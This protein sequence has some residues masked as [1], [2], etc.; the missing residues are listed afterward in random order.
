MR[1]RKALTPELSKR[2]CDYLRRCPNITLAFASVGLSRQTYYEWEKRGLAADD[3]EDE[4]AVFLRDSE[5]AMAD[6]I[7]SKVDS[8]EAAGDSDPRNWTAHA[9]LLERL[10]PEVFGR[11]DR[12]EHTGEGGGPVRFDVRKLSDEEL[13]EALGSGD[14]ARLLAARKGAEEESE[15]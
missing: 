13:D 3:P 7:S 5:Q 11:R 9:W 1:G 12:H 14:P 4:Y 6:F 10:K 15:G 2:I 8:I